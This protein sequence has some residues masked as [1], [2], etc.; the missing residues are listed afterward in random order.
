[1]APPTLRQL[2][3]W[4]A[5]R[6]LPQPTRG[7]PAQAGAALDAWLCVP[8]PAEVGDRLEIYRDGYPA[9]VAESL[10]ETYPAVAERLGDR[11]LA[12]L[13][14]RYTAAV[15]L[16]SY[17][18]NDAG[19]ALPVFLRSDAAAAARPWL[20]DLAELEWRVARAFHAYD[21]APLDPRALGWT[22]DDWAE[23]VLEFQP[24]VSVVTSA[25]PLLDLWPARDDGR[26][27]GTA[28]LQE[29]SQ[30]LI[31]RRAGWTVRC[32]PVSA[33][34]ARAVRLLLD[35]HR[36]G[37]AVAMLAAEGV[38]ASHVTEWFGRWTTCGLLSGARRAAGE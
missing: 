15:A 36:L 5:S 31:V 33:E 6:I 32:E 23:A 1:M 18:L 21:G 11:E 24:S 2:Q 16:A 19:A 3:E 29:A 37:D 26:G 25:W 30:H 34:E 14:D 27:S 17:N 10:A 38:D 28:E 8:A 35:G 4:M 22:V 13:T 7:E 20:A 12:A 9:R